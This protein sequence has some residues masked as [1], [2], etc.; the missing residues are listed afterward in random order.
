MGNCGQVEGGG[1]LKKWEKGTIWGCGKQSGVVGR[2][3][4]LELGLRL[5]LGTVWSSGMTMVMGIRPWGSHFWSY[6]P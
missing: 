4:R 1:A 2:F 5:G 3:S 6:I